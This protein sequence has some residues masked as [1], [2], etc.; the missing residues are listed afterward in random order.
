MYLLATFKKP[1]WTYLGHCCHSSNCIQVPE[2]DTEKV[3]PFCQKMTRVKLKLGINSATC[4]TAGQAAA[5]KAD[6]TAV[7]GGENS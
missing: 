2:K 7:I 6:P 1:K 3:L 4:C 5:S